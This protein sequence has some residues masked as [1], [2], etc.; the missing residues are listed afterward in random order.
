[1]ENREGREDSLYM[2]TGINYK[3]EYMK[4]IGRDE[5]VAILK[6]AAI[7]FVIAI[8]LLIIKHSLFYSFVFFGTM[9]VITFFI[10]V[11]NE[12]NIS[13]LIWLK[14]VMKFYK[15]QRRYKYIYQDE[16]R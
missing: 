12:N 6:V 14:Q 10:V 15:E 16:W 4:G 11:K 8:I 2:P 9:V 5:M 13:Q 7:S 3:K 1:M